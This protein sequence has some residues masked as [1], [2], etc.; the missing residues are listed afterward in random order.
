MD[1]RDCDCVIH[2]NL[3][4]SSI[5]S[6][7]ILQILYQSCIPSM[8]STSLSYRQISNCEEK[9][10]PANGLDGTFKWVSPLVD[11]GSRFGSLTF[12]DLF[13]LPDS[14]SSNRFANLV[15]SM[16][17]QTR[18]WKILIRTFRNELIYAACLKF[19]AD[20]SSFFGPVLLNH[21]LNF[22]QSDQTSPEQGLIF[23]LAP[24]RFSCSLFTVQLSVQ[25]RFREDYF[26]YEKFFNPKNSPQGVKDGFRR[27][28]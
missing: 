9:T 4:S 6:C 3:P 23:L 12:S 19:I 1:R 16:S 2:Y 8:K 21:I 27:G 14:M 28:E 24:L 7:S 17:D 22:L 5:D 13:A 26:K 20:I 10:C 15:F 11:R 18:I 25:F